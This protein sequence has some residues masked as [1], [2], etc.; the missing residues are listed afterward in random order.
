MSVH[1]SSNIQIN[2]NTNHNNN[3]NNHSIESI[4]RTRINKRK[5]ILSELEHGNSLHLNSNSVSQYMGYNCS[6]RSSTTQKVQTYPTKVQ[7]VV[8]KVVQA[9]EAVEAVQTVEAVPVQQQALQKQQGEIIIKSQKQLPEKLNHQLRVPALHL[10]RDI[11]RIIF[12]PILLSSF[13]GE[14]SRLPPPAKQQRQRQ[15]QQQQQ[16]QQQQLSSASLSA[17]LEKLQLQQKQAALSSA[18][19]LPCDSFNS[20]QKK[21]LPSRTK[22]SKPISIPIPVRVS[23]TATAPLISKNTNT[24]TNTTTT[25]S[26]EDFNYSNNPKANSFKGISHSESGIP[27]LQ[28][29]GSFNSKSSSVSCIDQDYSEEKRLLLLSS[30]TTIAVTTSKTT[31]TTIRVDGI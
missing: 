16:Q 1:P 3:N 17:R 6:S 2:T 27:E 7:A 22:S 30:A 10:E 24:N 12:V 14:E 19:P 4:N 9:V 26:C 23:S 5:K 28:Y 11:P 20:D 29:R 15:R 25:T 13:P 21:I 31:T 8:P 18:V